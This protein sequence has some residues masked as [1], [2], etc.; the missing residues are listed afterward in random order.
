MSYIQ[1]FEGKAQEFDP[2]LLRNVCYKCH[3]DGSD[4]E[5]ME[6]VQ[7]N[8]DLKTKIIIKVFIYALK[9]FDEMHERYEEKNLV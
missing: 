1:A 8:K 9:I 6:K 3:L 5:E 7:L 4:N 2:Q